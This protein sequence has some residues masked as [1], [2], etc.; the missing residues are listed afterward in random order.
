MKGICVVLKARKVFNHETLST[1][2]HTSVYRYLNYCIYDWGA[3]NTHLNEYLYFEN[4][5]IHIVNGVPPRTNTD[6]VYTQQ[7][8]LSVKR[9]HYYDI[10]LFMYK[11]SNS[12]LPEMFENYS[13]NT[14]DTHSYD[15]RKFLGNQMWISEAPTEDRNPAPIVVQSFWL[16]F[17]Q[18]WPMHRYLKFVNIIH[19]LL[20]IASLAATDGAHCI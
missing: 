13:D 6:Y 4:K 9:L 10:G 11:Y 18:P 17:G 5:I 7:N 16:Y 12:V 20:C 1:L 19:Q 14:E 3:Y 8:V 2:Y 15:I